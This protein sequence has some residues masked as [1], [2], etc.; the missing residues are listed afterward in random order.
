MNENIELLVFREDPEFYTGSVDKKQTS[1][2][3]Q[4]DYKTNEHLGCGKQIYWGFF[5]LRNKEGDVCGTKKIPIIWIE[6]ENGKKGHWQNHWIDCPDH[7]R[8]EKFFA[9]K[10]KK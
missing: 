8:L 6:K 5:D 2:C 9:D 7:D 1:I 4:Y 3:S 10:K